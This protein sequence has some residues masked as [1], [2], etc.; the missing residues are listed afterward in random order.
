MFE[1]PKLITFLPPFCA[2]PSRSFPIIWKKKE[3]WNIVCD[4]CFINAYLQ[5][6]FSVLHHAKA[7]SPYIV[8]MHSFCVI[9]L[10]QSVIH[11]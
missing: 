7:L 2:Y 8:V 4:I 9:P 3:K 11:L 10:S 1:Y 5:L 6:F